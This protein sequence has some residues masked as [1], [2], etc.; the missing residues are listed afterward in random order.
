M[1]SNVPGHQ[2]EFLPSG[3]RRNIFGVLHRQKVWQEI[4]KAVIVGFFC[5]WIAGSLL[6]PRFSPVLDW[7]GKDVSA[8]AGFCCCPSNGKANPSV[9]ITMAARIEVGVQPRL[10]IVAHFLPARSPVPGTYLLI[11]RVYSPLNSI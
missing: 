3:K 5:S 1:G 6:S 2:L 7:P 9:P 10:I 11:F 8:G 4:E